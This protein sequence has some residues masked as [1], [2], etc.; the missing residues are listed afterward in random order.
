MKLIS[1]ALSEFKSKTVY[2][3]APLFTILLKQF[4]SL[5]YHMFTIAFT[6]YDRLP[7]QASTQAGPAPDTKA[8]PA[9][10]KTIA[11]P[12]KPRVSRRASPGEDE[13]EGN[14]YDLVN[15]C[16]SRSPM[17]EFLSTV[18]VIDRRSLERIGRWFA[19]RTGGKDFAMTV[20]AILPTEG[21]DTLVT[22]RATAVQELL[23]PQCPV[24]E[25]KASTTERAIQLLAMHV[26][27][28]LE[29]FGH[30]LYTDDPAKEA[31]RQ[32]TLDDWGRFGGPLPRPLKELDP[33]R[34]D[35]AY[36]HLR[37]APLTTE[38]LLLRYHGETF[39]HAKTIVE[40]NVLDDSFT[41]PG[42]D[43]AREAFDALRQFQRLCHMRPLF[44]VTSSSSDVHR[45]TLILHNFARARALSREPE[46]ALR[47]ERQLNS[48]EASA[49]LIDEAELRQPLE[50]NA[51]GAC[52]MGAMGHGPTQDLSTQ[53]CVMHAMECITR[54]GLKL[55]PTNPKRQKEF[56]ESR[57]AFGLLVPVA[58][59][60][61]TNFVFGRQ[62]LRAE[63]KTGVAVN[64]AL[65]YPSF[66]HNPKLDSTP[67][68]TAEVKSIA[69]LNSLC[70]FFTVRDEALRNL[71]GRIFNH[72]ERY[73]AVSQHPT[74]DRLVQR[75]E[76]R[77]VPRMLVQEQGSSWRHQSTAWYHV[78]VPTNRG[79][80]VTATAIGRATRSQEAFRVCMLHLACL[81][82]Q[83]GVDCGLGQDDFS[84]LD[85]S[86]GLG[87]HVG[88][89][90]HGGWVTLDAIP[91][92]NDVRPVIVV[93]SCP[94]LLLESTHVE[95]RRRRSDY[96]EGYELQVLVAEG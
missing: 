11:H 92:Y 95:L 74:A 21:Q 7:R 61:S 20:D 71:I 54:L 22:V 40:V 51:R 52:A 82:R 3:F 53:L 65:S 29:H 32:Q 94:P 88:G 27:R 48:R 39:N 15:V 57:A 9:P 12:S 31:F 28:L 59:G 89:T 16:T 25:A 49:A 17:H 80:C 44:F 14:K 24:P 4:K 30:P 67:A 91:S 10:S 34:N 77:F 50:V 83:Q 5:V 6:I 8:N 63:D 47:V 90:E 41:I 37:R 68:P 87:R 33:E 96:A 42:F 73:L 86:Q 26:E 55:F 79:K 58:Y 36:A 70:D 43:T 72:V 76:R 62:K 69:R 64:L 18:H 84:L 19:C 45:T 81:L 56:E 78:Y 13:T 66:S 85:S 46:V 38:E 23:G 35:F 93:P 1:V 75:G 60:E 2:H